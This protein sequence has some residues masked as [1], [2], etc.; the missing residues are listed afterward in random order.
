MA[1]TIINCYVLHL[2]SGYRTNGVKLDIW[3]NIKSEDI[4]KLY[5]DPRYSENP[6]YTLE[7]STFDY[8]RFGNKYGARLSAVYQVSFLIFGLDRKIFFAKISSVGLVFNILTFI[9][10]T[11]T[12]FVMFC[13]YPGNQ[14]LVLDFSL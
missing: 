3:Y 8:R 2:N 1:S 4:D 5:D 14:I 10:L 7:L 6:D 13:I 9:I 11:H 12:K